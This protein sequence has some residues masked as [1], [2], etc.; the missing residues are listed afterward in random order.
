MVIHC[1]LHAYALF[2]TM[3]PSLNLPYFIAQG[4]LVLAIFSLGDGQD[5]IFGLCLILTL[6]AIH[7]LRRPHLLITVV[8]GY[9]LLYVLSLNPLQYYLSMDPSLILHKLV[10]S[11]TFIMFVLACVML[12]NQRTK[13]HQRDQELLQALTSAH[14]QL[15]AAHI[16]LEDYAARVEAL[17]LITERQRLARELHDTLAQGLVGLGMQLETINGLL[18][19]E[20]TQQ[21]REIVEQALSR[22]H[23][24]L[25]DARDAI[26]DLRSVARNSVD[27]LEAMREETQ[28]FTLATAIPCH[29]DLEALTLM[30]SP[31]H[32]HILRILREGL[33]NIARHAQASEV[34]IRTKRD[35]KGELIL[36]IRDNGMGFDTEAVMTLTGHYGLRGLQERARLIGGQ[37]EIISAPGQGTILHFTFPLLSQEQELVS[38][39]VLDKPVYSE[40]GKVGVHE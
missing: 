32:E 34:W 40:M 31:L 2:K 18:L 5:A 15:E 30:A 23:T 11:V 4:V 16:Q 33:T 28:G 20:R 27:D 13:A 38:S 26:D 8:G 10:S 29:A 37:M 36:E 17:T 3:P 14:A 22:V 9:L 35:E 21:A 39:A 7:L 19:R 6:E 1:V 12:Y 25:A 24:T